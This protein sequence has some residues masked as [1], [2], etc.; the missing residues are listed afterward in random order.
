[1]KLVKGNDVFTTSNTNL[2]SAYMEAG[3]VEAKEAPKAEAKA[4][5]KEAPK[6]SKES[7]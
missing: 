6:A 7:K 3:Y 1:M 2:I 4:K 5:A